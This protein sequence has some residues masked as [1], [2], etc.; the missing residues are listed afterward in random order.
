MEDQY[1]K[2]EEFNRERNFGMPPLHDPTAFQPCM[3]GLRIRREANGRDAINSRSWDNF[4]ATPPTKTSSEEL[5]TKGSPVYMDMLPINTRTNTVNYRNQPDYMPTPP[6]EATKASDLGVP[7]S[8]KNPTP[9]TSLTANN[10][11]QRLDITGFDSRN[12]IRELRG[13]VVEDNMERDTD[14]SRMLTQ[15][16][17]YDR[18]LPPQTATD[19]SSLQAYELL[20]P[21]QD[22][23]RYDTY[24]GTKLYTKPDNLPG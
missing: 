15:R 9:P 2:W 4:R 18:W 13:A 1:A 7:P 16:Q 5:K 19:A 24:N 23:W 12:L 17:F 6:R 11:T 22:Q 21:K 3:S 8:A 10:Y 20:R 14:T